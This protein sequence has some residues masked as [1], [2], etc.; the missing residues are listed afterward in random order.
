M[1][2]VAEGEVVI[3]G[4]VDVEPVGIAELPLVAVP[5]PVQQDHRAALGNDPAVVFDVLVT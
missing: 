5:R 4:A 1:N 3:D 2:A